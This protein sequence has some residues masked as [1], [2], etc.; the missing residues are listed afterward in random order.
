LIVVSDGSPNGRGYGGEAATKH[1]ATCK[2]DAK[3]RFGIDTFAIGISSAYSQREGDDMYGTGN[4]I[5]ISDVKSSVGY[6]SRFL[7]QVSQIA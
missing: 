3:F 6:L 4:N 1:V 2:K 5:V 7:N